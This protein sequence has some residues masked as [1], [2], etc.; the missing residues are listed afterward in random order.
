MTEQIGKQLKTKLS[1]IVTLYYAEAETETYPYAVYDMTVQERRSKSGVFAL[2]ADLAIRVYSKVYADAKGIADSVM[3]AMG[4]LGTGFVTKFQSSSK[5]CVEGVWCVE[6]NY[7][8]G[9]NF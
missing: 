5:D 2:T 8:V 3:T 6:L 4:S 1:S 7:F 9:Q